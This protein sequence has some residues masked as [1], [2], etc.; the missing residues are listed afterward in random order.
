MERDHL[1]AT[2]GNFVTERIL[3]EQ[4]SVSTHIQDNTNNNNGLQ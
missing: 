1:K 3:K 4:K 2:N